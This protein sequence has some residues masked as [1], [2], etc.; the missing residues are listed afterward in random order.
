MSKIKIK[1]AGIEDLEDIQ[2]IAIQT[3]NESFA[4]YNTAENMRMY[5]ARHFSYE[6][7]LAELENDNLKYLTISNR[8]KIIGY[9]KLK[10]NAQH[11][12][13]EYASTIEIE[14]F[15]LL[16]EVQRQG[17][18]SKFMQYIIQL[19]KEAGYE[20]LWL[21]VWEHNQK[22]ILFYEKMGFTSFSTK[23]FVLGNDI[24][25]DLCYKLLLH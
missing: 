11:P 8:D 25:K 20:T 10:F 15:Y 2:H 16:N 3:F 9:A 5:T 14:R 21:A 19:A 12:D 7:L 22:A 17:L 6:V 18:G 24:Q 1:E 13:L 23:A 4:L